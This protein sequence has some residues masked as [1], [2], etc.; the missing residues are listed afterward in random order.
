MTAAGLQRL[1]AGVLCVGFEGATT[2]DAPL[3]DLAALAPGGLVLFARNAGTLE[4]TRTL[5][6]AA[7]DA[8]VRSGGEAPLVAVD[9]E[10][11]RVRRLRRGAHDVPPM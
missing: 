1:A 11:G 4:E 6:D 9:Q 5:V 8:I 2:G 10:G 7:R 3:C